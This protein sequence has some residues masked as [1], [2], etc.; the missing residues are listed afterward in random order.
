MWLVNLQKGIVVSKILSETERT[1][2]RTW[3]TWE[4]FYIFLMQEWGELRA[5]LL[6]WQV[7]LKP[8]ERLD[9][10]CRTLTAL[11]R[12]SSP[13]W[14]SLLPASTLQKQ[15][16]GKMRRSNLCLVSS[17]LEKV[18]GKVWREL[19]P[20]LK[21]ELVKN[22]LWGKGRRKLLRTA[23]PLA[24]VLMGV[25]V[26]SKAWGCTSTLSL[27]LCQHGCLGG[28]L[29]CWMLATGTG[30]TVEACWFDGS[31]CTLLVARK[32]RP[33]QSA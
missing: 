16:I 17:A 8:L 10:E 12:R 32:V 23:G 19:V 1:K 2:K 4:V 14:C 13:C 21:D 15:Q 30:E 6:K 33:T 7:E 25:T 11:E 3:Q 24:L 22:G 31:S 27:L 9:I 29:E 18:R 5:Q 20:Q 26:D 28:N